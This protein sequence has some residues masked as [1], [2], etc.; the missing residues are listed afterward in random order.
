MHDLYS[1]SYVTKDNADLVSNEVLNNKFILL[2]SIR[3]P[4]LYNKTD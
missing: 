3:K 4:F 1:Y 2:K